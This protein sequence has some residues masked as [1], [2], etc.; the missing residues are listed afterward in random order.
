M[1]PARGV[2]DARDLPWLQGKRGILELL[3]HV[4]SPKV[5][6]VASLA[7]TAAVRLSQSQ[8]AQRYLAALDLLLVT[9]DDLPRVVFATGNLSL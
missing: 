8:L 9:L 2:H 6:Q 1:Q 4:S 5:A 7:G 3:L